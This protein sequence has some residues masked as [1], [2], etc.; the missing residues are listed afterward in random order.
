MIIQ[1]EEALYWQNKEE[2]NEQ[3]IEVEGIMVKQREELINEIKKY[4]YY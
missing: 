1:K 3:G 2:E 4:Y